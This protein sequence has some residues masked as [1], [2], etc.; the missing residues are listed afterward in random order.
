MTRPLLSIFIQFTTYSQTYHAILYD[1]CSV[2]FTVKMNVTPAVTTSVCT[3]MQMFNLRC[4]LTVTGFSVLRNIQIFSCFIVLTLKHEQVRSVAIFAE[5]KKKPFSR[6][7][8]L[9]VLSHFKQ[10]CFS[11]SF[12]VV[13]FRYL[14]AVP[15]LGFNFERKQGWKNK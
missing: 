3:N 14:N 8:E 11:F 10:F 15:Y 9:V 6:V 12:I 1:L 2:E 7:Y 5:A 13:L 4:R